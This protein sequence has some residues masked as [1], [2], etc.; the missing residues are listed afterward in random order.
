MRAPAQRAVLLAGCVE[1]S[2]QCP[3][4]LRKPSADLPVEGER[5]GHAQRPLGVGLDR[6]VQGGR[7]VG[8]VLIEER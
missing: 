4:G 5:N 1:R 6:V 3:L 2:G 7:E 8:R